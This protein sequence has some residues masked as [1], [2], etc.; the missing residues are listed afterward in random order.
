M[1]FTLQYNSLIEKLVQQIAEDVNSFDPPAHQ[2]ALS[3]NLRA[4]HMALADAIREIGAIHD[5]A[6]SQ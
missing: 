5:E 6:T 4:I 1:S 2:Q 3:G